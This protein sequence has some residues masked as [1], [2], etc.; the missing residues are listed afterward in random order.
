MNAQDIYG[1]MQIGGSKTQ[2]DTQPSQ[3]KSEAKQ[4]QAKATGQK[5]ASS[6]GTIALLAMAGA[7]IGS[8]FVLEKK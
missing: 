8:K 6:Y 3:D 7:L 2:D 1:N 4:S 5:G